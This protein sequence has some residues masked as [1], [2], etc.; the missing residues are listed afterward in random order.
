[1]S[2]SNMP[3]MQPSDTNADEIRVLG[4]ITSGGDYCRI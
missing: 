2:M 4:L 3:P 1:M